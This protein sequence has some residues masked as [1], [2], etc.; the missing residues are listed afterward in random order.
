MYQSCINY[1]HYSGKTFLKHLFRESHR[2][3]IRNSYVLGEF[4]LVDIAR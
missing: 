2:T 3:L 1:Q 4:R